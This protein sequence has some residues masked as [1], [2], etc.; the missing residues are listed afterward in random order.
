MAKHVRN[1]HGV[2][3]EVPDDYPQDLMRQLE[4]EE[5]QE[6]DGTKEAGSQPQRE[7]RRSRR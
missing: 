1:Q 4:L 7:G 2:V 6:D 5:V 3:S